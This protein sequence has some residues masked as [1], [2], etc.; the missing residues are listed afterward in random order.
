MKSKKSSSR[1]VLNLTFSALLSALGVVVLSIGS[2][3]EVLDLSACLLAAMI[4][5]I[6]VIEIGGAYPW[7]TYAV[8][9]TISVML[10]PNKFS[11]A[12]YILFAGNYPMLKRLIEKTKP[13][14]GWI[15]KLLLFNLEFT[16]IYFVSTRIF[17]ISD[18]GY[19]LNLLVYLLCNGVFILFDIT[20]TRMISFYVF[21]LRKRLAIKKQ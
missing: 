19:S 17:M 3:I 4:L 15:L 13:F 14:I 9:A 20:L 18:I 10:L 16:L 6:M 5:V 2:F 12:I 21:R 11:V 8:T 1:N 7:L